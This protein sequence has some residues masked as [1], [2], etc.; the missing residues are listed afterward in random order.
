[1]HTER[2]CKPVKV[3]TRNSH[4][5]FVSYCYLRS[6]LGLITRRLRLHASLQE[7]IVTPLQPSLFLPTDRVCPYKADVAFVS[8]PLLLKDQ[9]SLLTFYCDVFCF[10]DGKETES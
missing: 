8:I 2:Q 9:D 3:L 6:I 4:V 10:V 7:K 1:M 5:A